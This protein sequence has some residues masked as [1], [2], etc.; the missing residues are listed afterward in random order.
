ML[1]L[2]MSKN[3]G[4]GGFKMKRL[5]KVWKDN[6]EREIT[7]WKK[8]KNVLSNNYKNPKNVKGLLQ[9]GTI[10]IINLPN[11]YLELE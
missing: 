5:V 3:K 10:K 11:S 1:I 4:L 6:G 2:V 9:Q 8:E 7:T